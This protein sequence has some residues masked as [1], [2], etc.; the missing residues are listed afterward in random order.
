[1][2]E[3]F[4]KELYANI[5]FWAPEQEDNLLLGMIKSFTSTDIYAKIGPTISS[6]GDYDELIGIK[7]I[8]NML[9]A[10]F[11]YT[12][13]AVI[14]ILLAVIIVARHIIVFVLIIVAP[15]AI[16][17]FFFPPSRG[18][19]QKWL[20]YYLTWIFLL[21]ITVFILGIAN[22]ILATFSENAN[23]DPFLGNMV[24]YLAGI[25][26]LIF[27]ILLPLSLTN[28]GN[29]LTNMIMSQVMYGYGLFGA[30]V[31]RL[32]GTAAPSASQPLLDSGQPIPTTRYMDGEVPPSGQVGGEETDQPEPTPS[33]EQ[34]GRE[35]SRRLNTAA[36]RY[37]QQAT[38]QPSQTQRAIDKGTADYFRKMSEFS[39]R[40]GESAD[41]Y[42]QEVGLPTTMESLAQFP[43]SGNFAPGGINLDELDKEEQAKTQDAAN[44]IAK[45]NP[46]EFQVDKYAEMLKNVPEFQPQ[47]QEY[48]AKMAAG[49]TEGALTTL[50]SVPQINEIIASDFAGYNSIA[51]ASMKIENIKDVASVGGLLAN[52][53]N[54]ANDFIKNNK[55]LKV[56]SSTAK[57]LRNATKNPAA[58]QKLF[59]TNPEFKD[60][61]ESIQSDPLSTQVAL[62]QIADRLETP[63]APLTGQTATGEA[64]STNTRNTTADEI[65]A[66]TGGNITVNQQPSGTNTPPTNF[67]D[68]SSVTSTPTS[69]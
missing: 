6:L 55:D 2:S 14:I 26:I 3:N 53:Q 40:I 15:I 61:S 17:L 24:Q 56:D 63:T 33:A 9:I 51:P 64:I 43:P 27:A 32:L 5:T 21:P 22:Q 11:F 12:L 39:R 35:L 10:A 60:F 42:R 29:M 58:L 49:D 7:F 52:S 30:P 38:T 47:Y 28:F 66:N 50:A 13:P 41:R 59:E 16:M 37:D 34:K 48:T 68:V 23:G 44:Y 57:V 31:G 46:E 4:F 19:G 45:T 20:S 65:P 8:I 18:I 69:E 62:T 1:D 25:F 67:P 36:D 54:K